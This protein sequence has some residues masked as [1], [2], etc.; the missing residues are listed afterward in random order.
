VSQVTDPLLLGYNGHQTRGK[1]WNV[2][3][4]VATDMFRC[5]N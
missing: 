4:C 5:W 3:D 2:Y 1:Q